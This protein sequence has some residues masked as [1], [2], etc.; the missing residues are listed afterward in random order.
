MT[1]IDVIER[2]RQIPVFEDSPREGLEW[3]TPLIEI[4]SYGAGEMLNREG[5]PADHLT[6][7]FDG[8]LR[9]AAE[10]ELG[11]TGRTFSAAT[12]EI[13]GKLPYSRMKNYPL[14]IRAVVPSMVGLL[15]ESH[16]AELPERLPRAAGKLVHVMAD[17]VRES[18]RIEQQSD[19][20]ISLGKLSA[21]LAHE[22]NNPAAAAR[23][24]AQNLSDAVRALRAANL[25][26][27][28]HGLTAERRALV[29]SMEE[30]W[31]GNAPAGLDTLE[32][33]D[34]EQE[35]SEWLEQRGVEK[36]WTMAPDLVD[37]GATPDTMSALGKEFDG[38]VLSD[39]VERIT[40]SSNIGRLAREIES[41]TA[42]ISELV[43][44]IKEYSYMDQMPEQQIDVHDGIE[45]T[46]V[47]LRHRL[48]QGVNLVRDFDRTA[49]RI[50]AFGSELNQVWTN[51]IE[52]A[53]DAMDGRGDLRIR[54][55]REPAHVLVEVC[56]SGPGIA[57][58]IRDRI[59]DPFFTTKPVGKGTGLGLDTV[60]RIVR[61]HRGEIN[62]VSE[63]GNTR[64]QVRLPIPKGGN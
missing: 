11:G 31:D 60:Y 15:H 57:P 28:K 12:G 23:R 5:D 18:T 26:L 48:R 55:R 9:G 24:A 8:E 56:D 53:L 13:T 25:R 64:F 45:S 6:I 54:T 46:L 49:P 33:S 58:D 39:V 4:R 27:V 47:M 62:V 20:L 40:A 59:F 10:S 22:L 51:L 41:S 7:V 34:R 37:A 35:I 2:L 16:F 42:R 17:R 1:A 29:A 61:K 63:P 43:R 44:A 52:N 14:T 30:Q 3:L 36:A 19:K 32:R 50:C 21:G 38:E